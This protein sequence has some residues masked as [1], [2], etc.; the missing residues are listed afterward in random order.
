MCRSLVRGG[1]AFLYRG[2]C[3]SG[4]WARITADAPTVWLPSRVADAEP[5]SRVVDDDVRDEG[6]RE[7][8]QRVAPSKPCPGP[9][10]RQ[11]A[12]REVE[13]VERDPG[14]T[15]RYTP[16]P[17]HR[18]LQ[19]VATQCAD[20]ERQPECR[21]VG[22]VDQASLP[23]DRR[24]QERG[25]Q[26]NDDSQDKSCHGLVRSAPALAERPVSSLTVLD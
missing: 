20:S 1:S 23:V 7:D 25:A 19:R 11:R 6:K 12:D 4:G 2:L 26:R 9:D 13:L 14:L 17:L 24:L 16:R 15:G 8:Q 18:T 5:V 22:V 3:R 10:Q 21:P